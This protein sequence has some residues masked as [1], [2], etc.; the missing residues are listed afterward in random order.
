MVIKHYHLE[1][2][3]AAIDPSAELS[4]LEMDALEHEDP[5]V[6]KHAV[7]VLSN[8]MK[9]PLAAPCAAVIVTLVLTIDP[10][11]E[12]RKYTELA[13]I[14]AGINAKGAVKTLRELA[15]TAAEG[16]CQSRASKLLKI[17]RNVPNT[18]ALLDSFASAGEAV[19]PRQ[20]PSESIPRLTAAAQ[21]LHEAQEQPQPPMGCEAVEQLLQRLEQVLRVG[22]SAEVRR[23]ATVA[24]GDLAHCPTCSRRCSI[25]LSAAFLFGARLRS[26]LAV[27]WER[28]LL[29]R[30]Q[31]FCLRSIPILTL[32]SDVQ[33]EGPYRS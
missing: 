26:R 14:R 3:V 16:D 11:L 5:S 17:A 25:A 6:R 2:F 27:R 9:F 22:S 15:N 1:S 7:T 23:V 12:V 13:L 30:G 20:K 19:V 29:A 18:G 4:E 28:A 10:D 31:L 8:L 32:T 24:L 33:R 21:D